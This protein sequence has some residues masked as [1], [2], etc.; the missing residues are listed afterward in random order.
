[1]GRVPRFCKAPHAR[2]QFG[3]EARGWG[4]A[5]QLG[6]WT[7]H[8]K[9]AGWG[10]RLFD[11]ILYPSR[12]EI[13]SPEAVAALQWFADLINVHKVAPTPG[14][15]ASFLAGQLAID[16][17]GPWSLASLG[18]QIGTSFEWDVAAFPAGPKARA[19]RYAQEILYLWVDSPKKDA[20]W[21][22]MAFVASDA[23]QRVVADVQGAMPVRRS[24]AVTYWAERTD[25]DRR[26][27]IQ[28]GNYLIR[29]PYSPV[30]SQIDGVLN[31]EFGPVWQGV[32][33]AREAAEAAKVQID[34]LLR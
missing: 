5:T 21:E 12:S 18:Q 26:T 30:L 9:V 20:A 14:T 19:A 3:W 24:T 27:F 22:F 4:T 16:E 33:P 25:V 1:M 17:I 11:R 29:R 32:R 15:A 13:D 23:G 7:W 28:A 8:A 31:K 2:R 10:G 6:T 34:A